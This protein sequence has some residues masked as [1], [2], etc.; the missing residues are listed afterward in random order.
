VLIGL[1]DTR[2]SSR[3]SPSPSR[4]LSCDMIVFDRIKKILLYIIH[5]WKFRR[6]Q[7]TVLTLRVNKCIQGFKNWVNGI[8]ATAIFVYSRNVITTFSIQKMSLQFIDT[9]MPT[10]THLGQYTPVLPVCM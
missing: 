6:M 2:G 5:V 1:L 4:L 7:K 8:G 10:E 9:I 3:P